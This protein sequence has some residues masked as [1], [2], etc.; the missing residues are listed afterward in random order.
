MTI[1]A[2]SQKKRRLKFWYV[3]YWYP[4]SSTTKPLCAQRLYKLGVSFKNEPS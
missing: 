4:H 3:R 2:N 1:V